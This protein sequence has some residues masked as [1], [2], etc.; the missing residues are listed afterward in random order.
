[1]T[2]NKIITIKKA[3]QNFQRERAEM[4][5]MRWNE[6]IVRMLGW[7][8]ILYSYDSLGFSCDREVGSAVD[9]VVYYRMVRLL[10]VE[11]MF[12]ILGC[13]SVLNFLSIKI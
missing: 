8:S 10:V 6:E 1:M 11:G 13:Y 7:R 4:L 12:T 9:V 2:K 5:M 3:R